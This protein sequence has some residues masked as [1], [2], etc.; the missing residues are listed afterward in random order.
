MIMLCIGMLMPL[1]V[2]LYASF[3]RGLATEYEEAA[4]ID[5]ATP[6]PGLL[7]RSCCR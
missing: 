3:F 2:F 5:G 6:D 1:S 7:P 4:A